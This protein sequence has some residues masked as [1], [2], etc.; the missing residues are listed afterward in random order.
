MYVNRQ[1]FC[2]SSPASG[3]TAANQYK[4]MEL[5]KPGTEGVM[6]YP[7]LPGVDPFNQY[8][9]RDGDDRQTLRQCNAMTFCVI[10]MATNH[11]IYV[12]YFP[13]TD[14]NA[15]FLENLRLTAAYIWLK[16]CYNL[17]T[18]LP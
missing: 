14:I 15:F 1:H 8:H 12:L 9:P 3:V 4:P 17:K 16:I 6:S 13:T 7:K 10:G 18:F 11:T 2:L 5:P